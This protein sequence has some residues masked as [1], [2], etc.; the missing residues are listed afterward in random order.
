[1][2][3]DFVSLY[4]DLKNVFHKHGLDYSK[5][6]TKIERIIYNHFTDEL[7]CSEESL[8]LL[9]N[10]LGNTLKIDDIG[11]LL[12]IGNVC[13]EDKWYRITKYYAKIEDKFIWDHEEV[14]LV[15]HYKGIDLLSLN[16]PFHHK[17]SKQYV[18]IYL[19]PP[20]KKI[21]LYGVYHNNDRK[22]TI[23]N[24]VLYS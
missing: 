23:C 4:Q 21:S 8:N 24:K 7:P 2:N 16:L 10:K 6:C 3:F 17:E 18:S 14:K 5:V 22:K 13:D 15:R 1:M 19:I 20:N 9:A 12:V 11:T